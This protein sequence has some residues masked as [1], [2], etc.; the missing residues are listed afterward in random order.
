MRHLLRFLVGLSTFLAVCLILVGVALA[1]E[2]AFGLF[3][4]QLLAWPLGIL[5]IICIA[6]V[7]YG[8]GKDIIG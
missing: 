7:S 4:E 1:G 5:I 3:G 2:Y 8:L 6:S